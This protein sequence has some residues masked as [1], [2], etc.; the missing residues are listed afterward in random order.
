M[1]SA[2]VFLD[3]HESNLEFAL[4]RLERRLMPAAL[5]AWLETRVVPILQDRARVRFARGGDDAVGGWKAL[6]PSTIQIRTTGS[7]DYGATPINVRTGQLREYITRGQGR[8]VMTGLGA[9]LRYPGNSPTGILKEK[10]TTAQRGKNTPRTPARPV[11][12][13]NENDS[14]RILTALSVY[15]QLGG[16]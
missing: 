6:Q 16:I 7:I 8:T 3:I 15:I 9:T 12:G 11:I 4:R 10:V 2:Q 14:I 5:G 1:T 13:M